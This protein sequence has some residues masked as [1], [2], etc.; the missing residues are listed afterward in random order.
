M[1]RHVDFNE[2]REN[3]ARMVELQLLVIDPLLQRS[4][5]SIEFLSPSYNLITH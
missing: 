5:D 2:K 3:S 4:V 1:K